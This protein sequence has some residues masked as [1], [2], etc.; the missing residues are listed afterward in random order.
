MESVLK[1]YQTIR[2]GSEEPLMEGEPIYGGLR[3]VVN[4][5]KDCQE[6]GS[7]ELRIDVTF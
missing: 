4:P 7:K 6:D 5:E 1:S 3:Y 2:T